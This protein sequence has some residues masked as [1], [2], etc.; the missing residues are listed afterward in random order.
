MANLP[1]SD[2]YMPC[3]TEGC[4]KRIVK[5][6]VCSGRDNPLHK[7]LPFRTVSNT[8]L[9]VGSRLLFSVA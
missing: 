1:L 5:V 7:G 6:L 3:P 9:C 8:A 2:H 4:P